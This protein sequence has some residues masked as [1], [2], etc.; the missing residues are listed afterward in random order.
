MQRRNGVRKNSG[1]TIR[2]AD[3][4]L[5][6]RGLKGL[7]IAWLLTIVGCLLGS[8]SIYLEWI[9]PSGIEIIAK[10]ILIVSM[11]MSG[12]YVFRHTSK[13]ER[14]VILIVL[15][16]YLMLRYLLSLILTF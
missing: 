13:K 4:S 7:S 9:A 3:P 10:G 15:I 12:V 8:I 1:Q 2:A 6:K 5:W 14:I 16:L 11:L